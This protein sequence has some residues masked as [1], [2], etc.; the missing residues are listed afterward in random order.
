MA[1]ADFETLIASMVP[2]D[3][4]YGDPERDTALQIAVLR[5]SQDVPR[6]VV[7][8]VLW[9]A[10]GYEGPLPADWI[11]GC[12]LIAG[13]YPIGL[14]PP[15]ALDV[16]IYVAPGPVQSL[17][18]AESLP[19]GAE[20]RITFSAPHQLVGGG[21]PL[22]TIP[23]GHREA[24]ASY[25][26]FQLCRQIATKFGH[27]RDTVISADRSDTESRA[28]NFAAR[29]R[30]YRAGYFAGIGKADPQAGNGGTSSAEA[31]GAVVSWPSRSRG[32]LTRMGG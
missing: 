10:T 3:G 25:A 2:A 28:R 7:N 22:D 13:E 32:S 30:D 12:E 17:L 18:A 6:T 5:Y 29:A 9:A 16:S 31:A 21:A 15:E 8:D 14:R 27:E 26:A 23:L 11:D 24:V 4:A 19:A 1:L 20:A